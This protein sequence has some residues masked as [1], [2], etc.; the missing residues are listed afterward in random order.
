M[1][2]QEKDKHEWQVTHIQSQNGGKWQDVTHG[3]NYNITLSSVSMLKSIRIL[4]TIIAFYDNEMWKM[5][6]KTVF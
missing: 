4:I 3:V 1:G 6:V 2:D 5:Y